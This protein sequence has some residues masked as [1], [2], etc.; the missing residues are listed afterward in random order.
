M[1]TTQ[2]NDN[3]QRSPFPVHESDN[4][5]PGGF[6]ESRS[7]ESGIPPDEALAD[8]LVGPILPVG[9]EE[10]VPAEDEGSA[11]TY[12]PGPVGSASAKGLAEALSVQDGVQGGS[13]PRSAETN[14]GE[15]LPRHTEPEL[16]SLNAKHDT[17]AP[18]SENHEVQVPGPPNS[19]LFLV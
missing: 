17:A 14:A 16:R 12:L 18:R 7:L 19:E 4:L 1:H 3:E 5:A 8:A 13:A 11:T 9:A 2:S 15:G 10:S 6:P